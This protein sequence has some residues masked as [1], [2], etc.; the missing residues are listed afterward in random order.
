MGRQKEGHQLVLE[1]LPY[2]EWVEEF[3]EECGICGRPA[4]PRRR[5]ARDHDHRTGEPRG[6]LCSPCNRALRDWMDAEWLAKA[7]TYIRRP[8][9][10]TREEANWSEEAA[11]ELAARRP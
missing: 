7:L 2:P 3:G 9:K 11:P 6:L 8:N 4:P 5:L 10:W 1:L